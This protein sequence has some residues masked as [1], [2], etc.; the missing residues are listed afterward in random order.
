MDGA[1]DDMLWNAVK[2]GMLR[3]SVRKRKA[4]LMETV[5]LIGKDR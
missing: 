3:V 4:L 1:E 5:T 2:M